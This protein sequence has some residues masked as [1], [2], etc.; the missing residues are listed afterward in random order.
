MAKLLRRRTASAPQADAAPAAAAP[1]PSTA[2]KAEDK[3]GARTGEEAARKP[4]RR[5]FSLR[6]WTPVLLVRAA[7]PRLGLLT[8]IGVA[9]AAALS[10]REL[11]EVVL[12]LVTV[13][14]GQ[15]ILGWTNDVVDRRRDASHDRDKPVAAGTLDPGTA[16]FAAACGVL[17]VVPLAVSAG[18]WAGL[19]YLASL[20]VGV[21]GNL[22]LRR[23]WFSW[24]TWALSYALLPAYLAYGGWGGDG[25]TTPPEIGITVLAALL[26]VCVHVLAAR[27]GLVDDHADGFKH[28]PL[29]IAL[30][31]GAARLL[32]VSI[33]VTVVVLAALAVVG[34]QTGLTQ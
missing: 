30:R 11:R 16:L 25:T 8:A 14:V 5:R 26:G 28:L 23:G 33:G 4:S 20:A 27:P 15:C 2:E 29:R 6:L 9:V 22:V 7:H 34:S 17:L 21:L 31:T 10:G 1:P 19:S 3:T 13:L 24:V 12:V 32:W 18:V